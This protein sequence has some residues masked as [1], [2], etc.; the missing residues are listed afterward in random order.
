[1]AATD[2]KKTHRELYLSVPRQPALV[3]VPS[4][5]YLMRKFQNAGRWMIM[6]DENVA[7]TSQ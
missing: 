3:K 4:L 2:M 7:S 5:T 1:M 6:K